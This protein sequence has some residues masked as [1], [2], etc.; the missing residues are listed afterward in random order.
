M[1]IK[2]N[3]LEER[4]KNLIKTNFDDHKN[5][6]EQI[7]C[8]NKKLDEAFVTKVEFDPIKKVVYGLVGLVLVAVGGALIRLIILQ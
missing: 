7:E 3:V 4:M 5:I 6:L 8:I 1:A 2:I